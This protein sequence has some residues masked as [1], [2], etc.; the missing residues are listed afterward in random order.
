VR[1]L[2]TLRGNFC[3]FLVVSFLVILALIVSAIPMRTIIGQRAAN[4]SFSTA[5][6]V[7]NSKA[8]FRNVDWSERKY[9]IINDLARKIGFGNVRNYRSIFDKG[10]DP[11]NISKIRF[12]NIGRLFWANNEMVCRDD[13]RSINKD[14]WVMRHSELTR[15]TSG[16]THGF[17]HTIPT[18]YHRRSSQFLQIAWP[19]LEERKISSLRIANI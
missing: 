14:T 7:H 10:I 2:L 13:G 15:Y 5:L 18:R 11:A 4:V 19:N 1:A 8:I 17:V 6:Q 9:V 12:R 16:K 3:C